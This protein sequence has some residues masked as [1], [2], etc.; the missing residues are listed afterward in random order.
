MLLASRFLPP[1]SSY[2]PDAEEST[3]LALF[4]PGIESPN[5]KHLV[6]K[7]VNSHNNVFDAVNSIP[8]QTGGFGSGVRIDFRKLQ[9]FD[10]ICL[11]SNSA[12]IRET[13]QGGDRL[14][15]ENNKLLS[16]S[17]NEGEEEDGFQLHDSVLKLLPTAQALI[18][19]V[20]ATELS[21]AA[22][23]ADAREEQLRCCRLELRLMVR[24]LGARDR[25]T[26]V[27]VLAC[28]RVKKKTDQGI[29]L[30]LLA[31]SLG[32][33]DSSW[34]ARP[35][36]VFEVEIEDMEGM[37]RAL[38]WALYHCQKRRSS[39]EYHKSQSEKLM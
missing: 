16:A 1:K 5:T 33:T 10:L 18:Y 27:L 8:G 32:L 31:E 4:G 37:A 13:L 36:A 12:R 9:T 2:L 39:L 7:V 34:S 28:R 25:H 14:R 21:D 11:Y 29:G 22:L 19:A 35:W 17:A 23:A 24:G 30:G 6:H 20:D 26:P 38:D 15:A 3:R